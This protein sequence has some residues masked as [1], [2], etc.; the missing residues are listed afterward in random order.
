MKFPDFS[1]ICR[2]FPAIMS[3]GSIGFG[4]FRKIPANFE[5][6]AAKATLTQSVWR[7]YCFFGLRGEGGGVGFWRRYPGLLLGFLLL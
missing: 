4:K 5:Y 3:G 6:F 7:T 1:A 2:D